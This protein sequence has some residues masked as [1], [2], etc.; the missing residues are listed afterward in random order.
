ME[1]FI[2]KIF[3][4][5]T[6]SFPISQNILLTNN[7]T[8]TG[9]II[10]FMYR[11]LKCTFNT[12]FIISIMDDLPMKK[13]YLF[14]KLLNQ[15]IQEMKK[16][17]TINEINDLNPCILFLIQNELKYNIFFSDSEV[18]DLSTDYI[19]NEN[20]LEYAIDKLL[21]NEIYNHTKIYS[22]DCCGLGKSHL[23]KKEIKEKGE[24]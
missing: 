21:D 1:L 11:A 10:S 2:L 8:S 3:L 14:K 18:N 5:L 22:S 19:G 12:L 4:K 23:I 13:I 7:E 15:I 17:N 20:K 6:E 16:E 24:E 9:E